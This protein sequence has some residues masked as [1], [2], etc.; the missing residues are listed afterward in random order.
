MFLVSNMDPLALMSGP[1]TSNNVLHRTSRNT[2]RQGSGGRNISFVL[3]S[4]AVNTIFTILNRL[5][6]PQSSKIRDEKASPRHADQ[7]TELVV[8]FFS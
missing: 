2:Y 4:R 6:Y 7:P 1:S 3:S 5:C 8:Y